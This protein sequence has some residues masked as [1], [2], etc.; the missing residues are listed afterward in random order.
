MIII[1]LVRGA[2]LKDGI[3]RRDKAGIH[4]RHSK[5]QIRATLVDCVSRDTS[6]NPLPI[7]EHRLALYKS[8][9]ADDL[10]S[11]LA[12]EGEVPPD[13]IGREDFLS[14]RFEAF[15]LDECQ[16]HL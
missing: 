11:E 7:R 9:C 1:I 5:T 12:I 10:R 3:N 14:S 16:P 6:R 15:E 8:A 4:L 2:E 13:E